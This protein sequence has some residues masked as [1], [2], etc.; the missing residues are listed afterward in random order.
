M[1]TDL[2]SIAT[3]ALKLSASD[4]ARLAHTLV[5]SL[6]EVVDDDAE[7]AWDREIAR[8]MR[9]IRKGKVIGKPAHEAIARI[10][11]TLQ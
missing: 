7:A 2:E 3:G 6:D 1:R 10:R 8:R 9:A 11:S 4:R 5:A